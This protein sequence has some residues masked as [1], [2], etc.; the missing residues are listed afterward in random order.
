MKNGSAPGSDGLSVDF[1][2]FFWIKISSM[3]TDSFTESFNRGHLSFTQRQ[4]I[5]TLIHKGNDLEREL[6]NNWRPITLTNSDYKI[7]AKVLAERLG[8]VVHRLVK[9]RTKYINYFKD[10]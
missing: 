3:L 9:K 7:L 5:I 8:K 4:G 6:L 1:L 2:K 10:D